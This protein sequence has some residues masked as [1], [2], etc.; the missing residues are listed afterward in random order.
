V[1]FF[2]IDQTPVESTLGTFA[3]NQMSYFLT[4][5]TLEQINKLPKE[6]RQ[7][8]FNKLVIE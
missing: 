8:V 4:Q 5:K 7:Q 2:W 1:Q 3:Q 6:I